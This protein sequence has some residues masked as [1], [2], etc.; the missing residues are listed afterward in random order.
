MKASQSN[1]LRRYQTFAGVFAHHEAIRLPL[2]ACARTVAEL[3]EIIRQ[4]IGAVQT[5]TRASGPT[6]E[7]VVRPLVPQPG[8][9][10]TAT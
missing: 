5:Q 3:G 6:Q 7:A 10:T 8:P 2:P 9:S 1:E 4:I